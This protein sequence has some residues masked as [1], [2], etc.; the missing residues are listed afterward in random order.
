MKFSNGDR[1]R[2][3]NVTDRPEDLDCAGKSG[4]VVDVHPGEFDYSVHLDGDGPSES[5]GA[6]DDDLEAV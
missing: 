6:N 4:T 3:G 5:W 1:V 2:F